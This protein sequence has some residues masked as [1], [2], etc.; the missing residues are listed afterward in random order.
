[1]VRQKVKEYVHK[2]KNRMAFSHLQVWFTEKYQGESR[3]KC[4]ELLK[5]YDSSLEIEE[6]ERET[7][8]KLIE[9]EKKYI[10]NKFAEAVIGQLYF[11]G[12]SL[13]IDECGREFKKSID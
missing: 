9:Q 11:K 1:M 4:L 3:E 5:E 6:V 12:A 7:E 10:V 8:L 2:N 13:I